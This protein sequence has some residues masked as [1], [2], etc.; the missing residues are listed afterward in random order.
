[1]TERKKL[2]TSSFEHI[3]MQLTV[4]EEGYSMTSIS[5]DNDLPFIIQDIDLDLNLE[6]IAVLNKPDSSWMAG[7]HK[8][9]PEVFVGTLSELKDNQPI[10]Q[11]ETNKKVQGALRSLGGIAGQH[12]GTSTIED[13]A[14]FHSGEF[15]FGLHLM[16]KTA[17]EWKWLDMEQFLSNTNHGFLSICPLNDASTSQKRYGG[18]MPGAMIKAFF[19]SRNGDHIF[20]TAGTFYQTNS[21]NHLLPFTVFGLGNPDSYIEKLVIAYSFYDQGDGYVLSQPGVPPNS[22]LVL[23]AHPRDQNGRWR[24][25]TFLA[26]YIKPLTLA[27]I[28]TAVLLLLGGFWLYLEIKQRKAGTK[29]ELKAGATT[30][31]NFFF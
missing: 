2:D 23:F 27:L 21:R 24:L 4:E 12:P 13:L 6:I 8:Y 20:L 28:I 14:F 5:T 29:D 1:M 18:A 22:Q 16:L 11:S 19:R 26:P 9:H 31:N 10:P 30:T 3:T 7:R 17:T 25:E 15:P